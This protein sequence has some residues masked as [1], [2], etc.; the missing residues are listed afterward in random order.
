MRVSNVKGFLSMQSY[1]NSVHR[2]GLT[3]LFSDVCT[4]FPLFLRCTFR[5][6]LNRSLDPE[7]ILFDC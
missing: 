7:Q 6:N 1:K 4:L 5:F 3:T 2:K